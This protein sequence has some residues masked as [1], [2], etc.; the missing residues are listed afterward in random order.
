[1][2]VDYPAA[3]NELEILRLVRGENTGKKDEAA[4]PLEPD[5]IF[6][7]RKE[8]DQIHVAEAAERYIVDLVMATRSPEL[9]DEELAGWI[10]VGASPRATIALDVAARARAWLNGSEFVSPED[11]QAVAPACLAHRI[12]PSYAAEAAGRSRHDIVGEIL[13]RV[14]TV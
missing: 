1:M 12:H 13:K 7:A 11:I 8:V 10:S 6:A 14:A 9:H 4:S 3:E 5:A 2:R